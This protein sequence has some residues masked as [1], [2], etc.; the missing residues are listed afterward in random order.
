[1]QEPAP[2]AFVCPEEQR[3]PLRGAG[4]TWGSGPWEPLWQVWALF[5]WSFS[6]SLRSL[7]ISKILESLSRNACVLD[8]LQRNISCLLQDRERLVLHLRNVAEAI[9][10]EGPGGLRGIFGSD[11]RAEQFFELAALAETPLYR[12]AFHRDLPSDAAFSYDPPQAGP[13]GTQRDLPRR[14]RG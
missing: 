5:F 2:Q 4:A 11:Q 13:S 10:V 7:G 6:G 12:P 1:M 3:R 14:C 8:G 9:R